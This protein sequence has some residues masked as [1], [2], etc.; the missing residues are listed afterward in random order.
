MLISLFLC[1]V[2]SNA[3]QQG[4]PEGFFD[5]PKKDAKARHV[6]Y[7]DP[8]TDEWERF[9]K[10]IQK[11]DDVSMVLERG[12]VGWM[13]IVMIMARDWLGLV[14]EERGWLWRRGV[15]CGGEGLLIMESGF[16]LGSFPQTA[17]P[18]VLN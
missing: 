12:G 7:K 11:E 6:E 16:C 14:M 10:S 4:L 1:C 5:D 2:S 13:S 17:Q 9:Q 18:L 3:P 8:M 15:G